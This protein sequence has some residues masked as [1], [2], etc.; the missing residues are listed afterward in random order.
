M[1]ASRAIV[2]LTRPGWGRGFVSANTE[3]IALGTSPTKRLFTR[4]HS[5][6]MMPS[7]SLNLAAADSKT[8][9][10]TAGACRTVSLASVTTDGIGPQVDLDRLRVL[11]PRNRHSFV[12]TRAQTLIPAGWGPFINHRDIVLAELLCV[13]V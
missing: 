12:A 13:V 10:L 6:S 1:R 7:S 9:F 4:Y 11:D 2:R 8:L 3:E 5:N